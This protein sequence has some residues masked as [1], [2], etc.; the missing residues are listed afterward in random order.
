M[1]LRVVGFVMWYDFKKLNG[2]PFFRI[3]LDS[4]CI[5]WTWAVSWT[6]TFISDR[7]VLAVM[8]EMPSAADLIKF[9][10]AD[11]NDDMSDKQE[12][13][14]KMSLWCFKCSPPKVG[15]PGLRHFWIKCSEKFFGGKSHTKITT[16]HPPNYLGPKFHC[17]VP[18]TMHT[19]WTVLR[20]TFGRFRSLCSVG[21]A[22]VTARS[23]N[24]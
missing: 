11:F 1:A 8:K 14:K 21:W 23:E 6:K 2:W 20:T 10:S 24:G 17:I 13:M 18:K 7:L 19:L 4:Y 12:L 22:W 16:F 5:S 9:W 15:L 3:Q